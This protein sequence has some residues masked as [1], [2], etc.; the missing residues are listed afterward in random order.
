MVFVRFDKPNEVFCFF[1]REK[2]SAAS[3]VMHREV[4]LILHSKD[5]PADYFVFSRTAQKV[6]NKGGLAE[7]S[8]KPNQVKIVKAKMRGKKISGNSEVLS[9]NSDDKY[10]LKESYGWD[11]YQP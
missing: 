9:L 10:T 3:N 6:G 1:L 8:I 5:N 7:F 11:Y 4:A 2:G